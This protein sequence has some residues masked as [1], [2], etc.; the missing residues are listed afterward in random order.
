MTQSGETLRPEIIEIVDDLSGAYEVL[1]AMM[2]A[3][4]GGQP[5]E[6]D[7]ARV[8]RDRTQGQDGLGLRQLDVGDGD[9]GAVAFA[10]R[11]PADGGRSATVIGAPTLRD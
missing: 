2:V 4:P 5:D 3:P 10:H 7:A 6:A 1:R 11:R 9:P 8:L